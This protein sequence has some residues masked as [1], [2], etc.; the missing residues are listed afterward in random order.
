MM[1][2]RGDVCDEHWWRVINFPQSAGGT[3]SWLYLQVIDLATQKDGETFISD[4]SHEDTHLTPLRL[5]AV[6][7]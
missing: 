1:E 6:I 4:A 7:M 3:M 5:R 2:G